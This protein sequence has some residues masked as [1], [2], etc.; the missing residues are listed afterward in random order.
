MQKTQKTAFKQKVAKLLFS[1]L[2][3]DKKPSRVIAYMAILAALNVAV[4]TFSLPLGFVQFSFTLFLAALTGILIG[5]VFGF[6]TCV[7]GDALGYFLGGAPGSFSPWIGLSMG[8]AAV[9]AALIFN[10]I[11]LKNKWGTYI[12]LTIICLLTF[13]VCTY[14]IGTTSAYYLWNFKGLSYPAFAR[15]R[16]SVQIW[17]NVGNSILLFVAVP[18]L[19]RI[20]PLKMQIRHEPVLTGKRGKIIKMLG[21]VLLAVAVAFACCMA[22]KVQK[23]KDKAA[24][25]Q[26]QVQA[27]R[28]DK[29]AGYQAE[30]AKYDDYEVDVAFLGDS[31]TD[32]YNVENYY[33]Q[34]LVSNRGIGGETTIGLENRMQVSLYDLKPKV[35]VMLIGGNNMD[36]MFDNYE[37]I[38]KG[39]QQQVPNTKI[40][41]LS[42]TSM[43]GEWGKKNQLAAYNNVKIKMLAEKYGFAFVDLYSALLNLETGEIYSNYT[44]DGGH[45][46]ADGYKVLTQE[47]TPAIETQL[48]LWEMENAK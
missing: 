44:T 14:A 19:S 15:A 6:V 34:Y 17:N 3:V 7:L 11:P 21:Y 40:I 33:P 1:D 9:I 18:A 24:Q 39:F 25:V 13:V 26:A 48:A 47:I 27:Y 38:L 5:P 10:G 36:T 2:L 4:N 23:E 16:L 8:V 42:L 32:G 31:L 20:K 28:D 43:S 45:L 29:M 35:A 41:L 22:V 37:N 12:K 46:T 30:N